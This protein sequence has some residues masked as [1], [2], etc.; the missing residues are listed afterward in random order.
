MLNL[1]EFKIED[2]FDI[3]VISIVAFYPELYQFIWAVFAKSGLVFI[4]ENINYIIWGLFI[5]CFLPV[6]F[7]RV[8]KVDIVT[9]V[10]IALILAIFSIFPWYDA[11]TWKRYFD[12]ISKV[13]PFFILGKVY[14]YNEKHEKVLYIL[15]SITL[16]LAI[17][18]TVFFVIGDEGVNYDEMFTSYNILYSILILTDTFFKK[19]SYFYRVLAVVGVLYLFLLGTRGPIL[20]VGIFFIMMLIKQIGSVKMIILSVIAVLLINIYITSP[21]YEKTLEN[22]SDTVEEYGF[23]TRI[24]D[25]VKQEDIFNLTGRDSIQNL[26]VN[27][28]KKNP[29][30]IRGPYSDWIIV[31]NH[32]NDTP[33]NVEEQGV[34]VHNIFLEIWTHYGLLFGSAIILIL[35]IKITK[36]MSKT[37]ND[38]YFLVCSVVCC[39]LIVL[40][41]SSSYLIKESFFFLLGLSFKGPLTESVE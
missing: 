29:F 28:L 25:F 16:I 35:V 38:K 11:F 26:V 1:N 3:T 19:K 17:I 8:K 31:S 41:F 21:L 22:L 39:G 30:E 12:F 2:Y 18:Y 24:F 27:E 14:R 36:L 5:L 23:S 32:Y 15:A 4:S 33:G 7:K 13:L 20:C 34:Y 40:I 10:V 6:F 37:D 9:C